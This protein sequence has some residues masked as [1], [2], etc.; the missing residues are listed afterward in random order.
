MEEFERYSH[1]GYDTK[2][3]ERQI[4]LKYE[5][6]ENGEW[7]PPV[8][9]SDSSEPERNAQTVSS[10]GI[11]EII[12]ELVNDELYNRPDEDNILYG[13]DAWELVKE[14]GGIDFPLPDKILNGPK[15]LPGIERSQYCHDLY[16]DGTGFYSNSYYDARAIVGGIVRYIGR[17]DGL[18]SENENV[19]IL[20]ENGHYWLYFQLALGL[21]VKVGDTVEQFDVIGQTG[22]PGLYQTIRYAFRVI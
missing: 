12:S 19:I 8:M 5:K 20:D 2:P 11:N 9:I 10:D 14:R 22:S 21:N 6:D 17:I 4:A 18:N 7:H 1:G 13:D 15:Y 3:T 16:Y